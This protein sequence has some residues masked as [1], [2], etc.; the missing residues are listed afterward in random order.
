MAKINVMISLEAEV[1]RELERRAKKEL[2]P[3][4]ELVAEILRR[5]AVMSRMRKYVAGAAFAQGKSDDPFIE[6]FSR[7]GRMRA[8]TEARRPKKA[9]I[10]DAQ[11][12]MG[13][14]G[15]GIGEK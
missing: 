13:E 14:M 10:G 12:E 5:S 11:E 7:V 1:L 8:R 2:L 9:G 15:E 3:L 6:Y 4:Q